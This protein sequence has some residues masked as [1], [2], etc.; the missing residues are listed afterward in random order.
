MNSELNT[1]SHCCFAHSITAFIQ[2]ALNCWTVLVSFLV[3][4]CCFSLVSGQ[5]SAVG[6]HAFWVWN[7]K[8][9]ENKFHS[10][11]LFCFVLFYSIGQRVAALFISKII[12]KKRLYHTGLFVLYNTI[13]VKWFSIKNEIIYQSTIRC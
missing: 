2:R 8:Q 11:F 6:T 4:F 13:C 5:H 9:F 10:D 3:G 7:G 12:L 1:L